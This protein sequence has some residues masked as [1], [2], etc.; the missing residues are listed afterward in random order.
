[1]K[2]TICVIQF[3]NQ[4]LPRVKGV[5]ENTIRTYHY[6]FSIFLPFAAQY[7]CVKIESLKVEHLSVNLLIAFLDY[8]ET[9]RKNI[10]STRN[11]RLAALKSFSKMISFLYPEEKEFI[12]MI[13]DIPQKKTQKKLTGF[14]Y[15]DEIFK[16]FDSVDLKK[17]K[18]FVIIPCFT[19]F[20]T[21]VQEQA[22]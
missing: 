3:F 11:Q 10:A 16:I 13:M 8:L 15:E 9:Q 7:F 1:M 21:Q 6:T 14:L 19:F 17:K 2:L 12:E 5:S 4:Y 20:M 22:K 18:V